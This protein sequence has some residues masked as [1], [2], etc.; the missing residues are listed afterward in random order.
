PADLPSNVNPINATT[1][2]PDNEPLYVLHGQPYGPA[3][4]AQGNADCLAG[5]Y[6]YPAGPLTDSPGRYPA[7]PG[8]RDPD[9]T[10]NT[11]SRA[12]AGGSHI[13]VA[14]DPPFDF[15]PTFTGLSNL[16][17]VDPKLRADGFKV[18]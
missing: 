8:T 13:V 9:G 6:G 2:P 17:D 4:D 5:Q 16:R 12:N 11:W 10:Y 7:V 14:N 1:G 18:P 15:G 3:I